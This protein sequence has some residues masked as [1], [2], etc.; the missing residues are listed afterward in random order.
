MKKIAL[1][2]LFVSTMVLPFVLDMERLDVSAF[3]LL[4][5]IITGYVN[6]KVNK[7]IFYNGNKD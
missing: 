3:L 1:A 2:W 6:L 4:N 5:L 7:S